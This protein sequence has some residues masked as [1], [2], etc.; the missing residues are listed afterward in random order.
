MKN[1][2]Q[3]R[4]PKQD[5]M[6][7]IDVSSKRMTAADSDPSGRVSEKNGF[8]IVETQTGAVPGTFGIDDPLATI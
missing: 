1:R 3:A 8:E 4:E 7:V 5:I 6:P 2:K